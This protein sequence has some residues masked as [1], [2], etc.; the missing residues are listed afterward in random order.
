MEAH[1]AFEQSVIVLILIKVKNQQVICNELKVVAAA[2]ASLL[3][4]A[5]FL[6]PANTEDKIIW[7]TRH[8]CVSIPP[9]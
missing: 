2:A 6:S 7:I 9:G 8:F 1:V 4:F 3:M 5:L